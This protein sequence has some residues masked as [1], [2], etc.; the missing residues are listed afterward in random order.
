MYIELTQLE[1]S[2]ISPMAFANTVIGY[3]IEA[4]V[5]YENLVVTKIL[6]DTHGQMKKELKTVVKLHEQRVKL[7]GRMKKTYGK[8]LKKEISMVVEKVKPEKAPK[9]E[10]VP[11]IVKVVGVPIEAPTSLPVIREENGII[12][13]Y[14]KGISHIVDA[15]IVSKNNLDDERLLG[16][17]LDDETVVGDDDVALVRDV[18][19]CDLNDKIV[20]GEVIDKEIV[21]TVESLVSTVIRDRIVYLFLLINKDKFKYNVDTDSN[22]DL[23]N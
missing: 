23:S 9:K 3:P 6:L 22:L 14:P 16:D 20:N 7:I 4:P 17:D 15:K 10:K 5:D 11:K 1:I 19:G 2:T 13:A 18:F 8:F 21:E 12:V